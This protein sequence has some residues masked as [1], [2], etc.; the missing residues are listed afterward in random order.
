MNK[1]KS[2]QEMFH[3]LCYYTVA[4]HDP[5]FIHQHAVDAFAAQNADKNTKPITLTF[6]LIGLYLL[7][8][9]N[10]SGKEVQKAHIKL[11]KNQKQWPKFNLPKYR[12][13]IRVS[14]VLTTLEGSKRDEAIIK[15]CESVWEAYNK[16]HEKVADLVK[17]GYGRPVN[18]LYSLKYVF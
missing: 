15:W 14:N 5:S 17:T 13:N 16:C 4:H 11:G 8:E 3:N 7:I 1:E 6:A 10:F 9:K 2:E 18:N 12:G